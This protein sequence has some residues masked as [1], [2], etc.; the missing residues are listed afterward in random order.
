EKVPCL[1]KALRFG[2]AFAP[3]HEQQRPQNGLE[4]PGGVR[5]FG[6]LCLACMRQP[7]LMALLVDRRSEK[8]TKGLLKSYFPGAQAPRPRPAFSKPAN[9]RTSHKPLSPDLSS[10]TKTHS[11]G[12]R[13]F[14]L[15]QFA[16]FGTRTA[17]A[18]KRSMSL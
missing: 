14:Q 13:L 10:L 2:I 6:P 17:E 4:A 1:E 15:R 16:L 5:W 11:G 3:N 9:D 7:S 12:K 8:L 18:R